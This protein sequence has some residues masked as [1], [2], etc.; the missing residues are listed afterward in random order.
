MEIQYDKFW[1]HTFKGTPKKQLLIDIT[2]YIE[3][4][5]K[6]GIKKPTKVLKQ[7]VI[8]A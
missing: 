2:G 5:V 8:K 4:A 6:Q 3:F 7:T 1:N